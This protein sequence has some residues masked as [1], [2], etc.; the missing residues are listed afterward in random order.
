M[1]GNNNKVYRHTKLEIAIHWLT[2]VSGIALI[3][4]GLGEMPM[5]K[6]YNITKLPFLSFLGSYEI[7]LVI[8]YLF[9]SLFIF[10]VFFHIVYHLR[11]KELS[12]LP[13]KGDLKESY[14]VLKAIIKGEKEPPHEKFLAEQRLAYVAIGSVSLVLIITGLIKTYKN[15]GPVVLNPDFLMIVTLVHTVFTMFF[16]ILFV[17]HIGAFI[18]K[19]NRELLKSMFTGYVKYEYAKRRHP[20]WIEQ[21][22]K[23]SK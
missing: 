16:I 4:S 1:K 20:K 2:A 21:I 6:R 17:L 8:H 11:R 9:A 23:T 12:L 22:E 19:D 5:Y 13:K 18:V 10:A 7:N 14:L 15:I 3:I